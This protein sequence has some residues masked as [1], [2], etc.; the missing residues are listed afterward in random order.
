MSVP[1]AS[2]WITMSVHE[3]YFKICHVCTWKLLQD[4]SCLY[5]KILQKQIRSNY[6]FVH[7]AAFVHVRNMSVHAKL[8]FDFNTLLFVCFR[9]YHICCMKVT[10]CVWKLSYM[11]KKLVQ[12]CIRSGHYFLYMKYYTFIHFRIIM[13]VHEKYFCLFRVITSVHEN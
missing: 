12:Y 8:L 11:Y 2:L 13:W 5:M 3:N 4:L 7:K 9:S 6:L 1:L 10:F